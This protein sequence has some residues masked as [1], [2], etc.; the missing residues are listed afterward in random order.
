MTRRFWL[1]Y[2]LVV[3]LALP[4]GATVVWRS[5]AETGPAATSHR[6]LPR[7]DLVG[8]AEGLAAGVEPAEDNRAAPREG[9]DV[10]PVLQATPSPSSSATPTP[11]PSPDTAQHGSNNE[12]EPADLARSVGANYPGSTRITGVRWGRTIRRDGCGDNLPVTWGADGNL[13]AAFGDCTGFGRERAST[14]LTRLADPGDPMRFT[15]RNLWQLD[16]GVGPAGRKISGLISIRGVLYA[17]FRN[18]DGAGHEFQVGSSSDNGVRWRLASWRLPWGYPTFVNYGKDN[19]GAPDGYVYIV[20]PDTTNAYAPSTDPARQGMI[21]MRVPA[22]RILDRS[23]YVYFKGFWKGRT[24]WSI[25]RAVRKLVFS[26]A[27]TACLRG[28]ISYDAP[29]GR[30]LWWQQIYVSGPDTRWVGG[31]ALYEAPTLW[32]PWRTVYVTPD[33]PSDPAFHDGPGEGGTFPTKWISRD[34]RTLYF[35]CSCRNTLTVRRVVF[36]TS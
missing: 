19:R 12:S 1:T 9:P 31:F 4:G 11:V 16:S 18:A 35:V 25:D 8:L 27:R 36:T 5:I 23:A 28:Q 15:G 32:G 3:G 10:L 14:T 13:Y 20:S 21:L 6:P 2:A 29:L 34:G 26:C 33:A 30:Y 22:G 17:L 24:H 7:L